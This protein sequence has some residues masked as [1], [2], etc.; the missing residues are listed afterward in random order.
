MLTSAMGERATE[1]T[2]ALARCSLR[3]GRECTPLAMHTD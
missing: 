3:L 1:E 2:T